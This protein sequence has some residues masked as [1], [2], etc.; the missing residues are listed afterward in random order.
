MYLNSNV[1]LYPKI[2]AK[3]RK[4]LD[5]TIR[6]N[7]KVGN[8]DLNKVSFPKSN[9]MSTNDKFTKSSILDV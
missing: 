6:K 5:N 4:T 9:K 8:M 1:C 3:E 2:L 7:R